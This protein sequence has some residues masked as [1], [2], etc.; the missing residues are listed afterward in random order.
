MNKILNQLKHGDD[1]RTIYNNINLYEHLGFKE[2]RAVNKSHKSVNKSR[3]ISN[4]K[5]LEFI[6]IHHSNTGNSI[7]PCL[8]YFQIMTGVRVGNIW[9]D[10]RTHKFYESGHAHEKYRYCQLENEECCTKMKMMT[11][12]TVSETILIL[13]NVYCCYKNILNYKFPGSIPDMTKGYN[14]YIKQIFGNEYASHDLR[15]ILP[16]FIN[17]DSRNTGTWKSNRVIQKHYIV[18]YTLQ[19]ALYSYI[20]D[21]QIPNKSRCFMGINK[22]AKFVTFE[23]QM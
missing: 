16:N 23:D 2:L 22:T 19:K 4:V 20:K 8:L 18:G 12:T 13:P 17:L 9:L 6:R 11:K 5:I 3:T 1:I 21:A 14:R 15:R 7:F 10:R